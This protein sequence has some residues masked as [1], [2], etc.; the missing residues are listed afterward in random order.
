MLALTRC[1]EDCLNGTL[2]EALNAN[3]IAEQWHVLL[4]LIIGAV[5]AWFAGQLH[6]LV[7]ACEVH[8]CRRCSERAACPE[9][10]EGAEFLCLSKFLG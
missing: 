1:I 3:T 9:A 6:E 5:R 7:S 8:P 2:E 4:T 10:G